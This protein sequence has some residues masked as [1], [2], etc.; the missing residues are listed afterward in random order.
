MSVLFYSL[1]PRP[2]PPN[3]YV[4]ALLGGFPNVILP[5][6]VILS[7]PMFVTFRLCVKSNSKYFLP[8]IVFSMSFIYMLL[9]ARGL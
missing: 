6:P 9:W 7:L 5:L 2:P 1:C 3:N 8:Y 4:P